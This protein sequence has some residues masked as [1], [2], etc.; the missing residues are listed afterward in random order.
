MRDMD[1]KEKQGF[2][3]VISRKSNG[4]IYEFVLTSDFTY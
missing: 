4:K 2:K 1:K 3:I